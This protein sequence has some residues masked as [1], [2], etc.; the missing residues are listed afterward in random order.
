MRN[1]SATSS[2]LPRS[3]IW[4]SLSCVVR[5]VRG[6]VAQR[7]LALDVHV[8]RVVLYLEARLGGVHHLP[9]DH[10]GDLD[11]I[12]VEVV[13]LQAVG[14]EVAHAQRDAAAAGERVDPV[15]TLFLDRADVAA[16]QQD[17]AR[18]VRRDDLVAEQ[19]QER[20]DRAQDAEDQRRRG[21]HM[22]VGDA[23][24]TQDCDDHEDQ[25][26]SEHDES[27]QGS[28]FFLLDHDSSIG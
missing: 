6:Q 19:V 10:G 23:D 5:V 4:S 22:L 2:V 27:G 21:K 8:V 26:H 1:F 16:E 7:G 14:L 9:D 28:G 12:A 3:E 20:A 17:D 18:L 11:R 13:D 24:E 25:R 15:P